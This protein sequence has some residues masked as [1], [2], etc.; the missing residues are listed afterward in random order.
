VHPSVDTQAPA[1][2]D[3]L[4]AGEIVLEGPLL[5]LELKFVPYTNIYDASEY[6]DGS[7]MGFEFHF[8]DDDMEPPSDMVCHALALTSADNRGNPW[9]VVRFLILEEVV[10]PAE[11]PT[12]R[13]VGFGVTSTDR[14]WA[15]ELLGALATRVRI[16]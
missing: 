16:I 5:L 10:E 2:S 11:T 3:S 12:M 1:T 7:D 13:R 4:S 15:R 6:A 8:L 9:R 14:G